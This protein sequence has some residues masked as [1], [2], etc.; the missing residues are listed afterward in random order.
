[1]YTCPQWGV[2]STTTRTVEWS[3]RRTTVLSSQRSIRNVHICAAGAHKDMVNHFILSI[4]IPFLSIIIDYRIKN[5]TF[6]FWQTDLL[7]SIENLVLCG[8]RICFNG[9]VLKETTC[10]CS[11]SPPFA[12]ETCE[13]KLLHTRKVCV[14]FLKRNA[15]SYI[16]LIDCTY[17]RI[18]Y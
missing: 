12:G 16:H 7:I 10:Q 2:H 17:K 1:M 3:T 8:G 15:I 11:C 14:L 4:K 5:K 13:G 18:F 9:G 6:C